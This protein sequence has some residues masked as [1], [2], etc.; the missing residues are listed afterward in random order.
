MPHLVIDGRPVELADGDDVLTAALRAGITLPGTLCGAGDCPNCLAEIDGVAYT[1]LCRTPAR[2]GAVVRLQPAHPAPPPELPSA[3]LGRRVATELV[4]VDVAVVGGGSAGRAEAAR[5]EAE[6]RRVLLLDDGVG[7]GGSSGGGGGAGASHEVAGLYE[8]PEL[9]VRSTHG[10]MLRVE[11]RE[12]VVATGAAEIHPVCPGNRLAGLVTARAATRLAAAGVDLGRVVAVGTPP[13]P[14]P[15]LSVMAA[16]GELVRFEATPGADVRTAGR[17]GAVV[18]RRADGTEARHPCD[19][20]TLGLGLTPRAVLAGMGQG[21]AV[22]VVGEA[23]EPAVLPPPPVEGVVCPCSGTTVADLEAVWD[24]GFRELELVK[25]ASLAGTGTCQGSV[26]MPHVRSFLAARGVADQG[27]FTP[28][29]LVR[30]ITMAEAAAGWAPPPVRR[31]A[32]DGEH[33]AL[34]ARMDRFGGWWRPWRY[35]DPLQEYWAVREGVSLGDVGTLGKFLLAGPDV[36]D[37]LEHLYPVPVADL[38]VGRCRYALNLAESGAVLDDGIVCRL[39][40][41]RFLLTFTTGGAG[42]AEAWLRD[43]TAAVAPRV[44]ILDRTQSWGAINVTG[45]LAGELLARLGPS[46][47]PPPFLGHVE[48]SVS[49]VPCHVL[50]LGFTGE[51]SYELHHDISRSVELW[52]ALLAAGRDLGVKPHGIDTLFTLRLEKGH[53]IVGMD[54]EPDST[55]RRLGL[56]RAV[57]LEAKGDFVGRAAL[58]RTAGIPPDRRL[59]GLVPAGDGPGW[60]PG[61]APD[62]GAVIRSGPGLDHAGHVTSSRWSPMLGHPVLLGW[63]ALDEGDGQ[64]RPDLTIDGRPVR[65]APTPFLDPE[66]R[67]ARA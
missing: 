40:E 50:R 55:P 42:F 16:E 64:P 20:V 31:T 11:A 9:L 22:R 43:W 44:H 36:L 1:R 47:P 61:A 8:G 39:D 25:R 33:R 57:K 5:L 58:E 37:L 46:D 13:E 10:T 15:G 29:P 66:G 30:Q 6:G 67:R 18:V 27:S 62:E 38:P 51:V 32:L 3:P 4:E 52:R 54:T 2:P 56:D 34:G 41:H 35:G 23:A 60:P 7:G 21:F 59:V 49:G 48:T 17:V 65:V 26:C 14:A 12:V 28:R 24:R 63:V 45:P 19:T 53:V